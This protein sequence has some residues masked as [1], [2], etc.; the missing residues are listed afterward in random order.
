MN[1]E[2]KMKKPLHKNPLKLYAHPDFWTLTEEQLA[3]IVGGCGPGGL[4][5]YLVP[6]NIDWPWP[7]GLSIKPAC[8]IHDFDYHMGQ[9]LEDKKRGDRVF[10]NNMIRIIQAETKWSWVRRRR[11]RRANLYY[12]AVK[13]FGAPAFWAGKNNDAE[14]QEVWI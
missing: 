13:Q 10:L 3:E 5:D 2:S 1:R 6:D 7:W 12:E 9:T 4:G 8:K 14:F 11:L